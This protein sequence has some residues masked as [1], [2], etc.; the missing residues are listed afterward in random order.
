MRNILLN[1]LQ[2]EIRDELYCGNPK[3][4]LGTTCVLRGR[5]LY[6]EMPSKPAL[7][8]TT[9]RDELEK[10]FAGQETR[11]LKLLFYGFA[12]STDDIH[13]LAKDV[14]CFFL[15][16]YS[17]TTR[18]EVG[19]IFFEETQENSQDPCYFDMEVEILYS[20][21]IKDL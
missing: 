1:D 8:F 20:Y 16:D 12:N 2:Q 13:T 21:T 18:T 6:T 7:C 9:L 5:Y 19:S 3:Y 14:Q 15:N 11:S 10:S 4:D 17:K